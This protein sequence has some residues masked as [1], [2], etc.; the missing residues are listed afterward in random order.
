[1][2]DPKKN[3]NDQIV[4]AL[5]DED[6]MKE[7][8]YAKKNDEF[9]LKQRMKKLILIIIMFTVFILVIIWLLSLTKS[10]NRSFA[11]VENIMSKAAE[12]YYADN[13]SLLPKADKGT[14]EVS[15][16]KLINLE[17]M[18]ELE[19][20]SSK[21]TSCS[22]K[23]VVENNDDQYVYVPYLDCGSSYKTTELFRKVTS[24]S[25]IVTS[26][27]GLYSMNG[28]YVFRGD[29][30]NNYVKLGDNL[31]R[32][33]KVDSNDD[34]VLILDGAY[35]MS[36]YWDDRYNTAEEFNYGYNSFKI[37]RMNTYLTSIYTAAKEQ[38]TKS[39]DPLLFS[40]N[41]MK[42]LSGYKLCHGIRGENDAFNNNSLECSQTM[43]NVKIGLLT[44]SDYINA[45]LDQSCTKATD[46]SCQN[47]NYLATHDGDWWLLTANSKNN[48]DVYYVSSS[49]IIKSTYAS[50][51]FDIRPVIH[52]NSKT[53]YKSGKGTKNKPYKIK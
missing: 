14:N 19:K 15:L 47:Y 53:M 39:F 5:K 38:D 29:N 13:K 18:K 24:S 25:N 42:H 43:D 41:T 51:Y 9:L 7:E 23:V 8:I 3:N 30:V 49:G 46:V 35:D 17:Y 21:A 36:T 16:Q 11:D 4:E 10:G 45:S 50:S 1:M 52:L 6:D 34:V 28:E 22:G 2:I 40:K 27:A 26:D 31:W 37:S 44:L 48:A 12:S 20:Y 33:V 32:I